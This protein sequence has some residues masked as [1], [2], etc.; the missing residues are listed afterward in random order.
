MT[1]GTKLFGAIL[2]GLFILEISGTVLTYYFKQRKQ[3][4]KKRDDKRDGE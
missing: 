1:D 3:N 4:E 2:L